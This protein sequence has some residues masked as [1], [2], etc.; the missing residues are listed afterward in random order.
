MRGLKVLVGPNVFIWGLVVRALMGAKS[1]VGASR[2]PP[3]L[4]AS[5]RASTCMQVDADCTQK[6]LREGFFIL[7]WTFLTLGGIYKI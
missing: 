6:M 1:F 3:R 4:R 7:L 2:S 5:P